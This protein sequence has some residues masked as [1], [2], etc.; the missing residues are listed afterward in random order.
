MNRRE[1]MKLAGAVGAG[2]MGVGDVDVEKN[3]INVTRDG[4][5][6]AFWLPNTIELD[7]QFYTLQ[8]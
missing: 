1:F 4:E 6:S 2:L 8:R 5:S 7:P 3:C